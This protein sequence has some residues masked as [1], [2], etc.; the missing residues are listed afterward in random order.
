ML[1]KIKTTAAETDNPQCFVLFILSHGEEINN[2]EVEVVYG[3][4][5]KYL[6]KR[7]IIVELSGS[8][9]PSLRGI[10]RVVFFQCC[11]GSTIEV[12][13]PVFLFSNF[14]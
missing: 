6:T 10:P 14:L 5:G 13:I 9:C 2:Q 3:T 7:Q 4:D 11:R 1:E 12:F 8:N